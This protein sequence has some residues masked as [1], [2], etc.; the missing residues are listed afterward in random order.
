ML[1]CLF[2]W[3]DRLYMISYLSVPNYGAGTGLYEIDPNL[4]MKKVA[5]HSSVFANRMIHH[6]TDTIIIGPY[7]I[8]KVANIY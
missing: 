6:W 5:N 4:Q 2:Q 8:D 3:A 7:I 1:T